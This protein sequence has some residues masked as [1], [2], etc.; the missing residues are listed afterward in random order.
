MP[1]IEV[2]TPNADGSISPNAET[3]ISGANGFN[4]AVDLTEDKSTG[5]IYVAEYGAGQI[6]LLKP[7]T[8][9][10]SVSPDAST[11]YLNDV[12]TG[13]PILVER[14]RA[15]FSPSPTAALARWISPAARLRSA[16]PMRRTSRSPAAICRRRSNRA[17]PSTSPSTSLRRPSARRW[18]R[19][20]SRAIRRTIRSLR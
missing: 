14:P 5:F 2:L 20:P 13:I 7:Q 15:K 10:G 9:G 4:G 18:R 11:M 3:D 17:S 1:D 19:S 12:K 6:D 8:T 16:E